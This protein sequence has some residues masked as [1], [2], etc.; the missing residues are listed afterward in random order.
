MSFILHRNGEWDNKQ[1]RAWLTEILVK[2]G[3]LE[4]DN[5]A[6]RAKTFQGWGS[7]IFFTSVDRWAEISG[8]I[9]L[10]KSIFAI[11]VAAYD[12]EGGVPDTLKKYYPPE[13]LRS[14][15]GAM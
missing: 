15:L 14:V 6:R 7:G 10:G 8:D 2:N 11:C 9:G 12:N 3:N 5:A 4:R 1:C 13:T